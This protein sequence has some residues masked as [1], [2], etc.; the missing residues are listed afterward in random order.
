MLMGKVIRWTVLNWL[1][2]VRRGR[3]INGLSEIRVNRTRHET[4]DSSY[5][6]MR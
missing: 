1:A 2:L 3:G 6:V 5:S 4:R